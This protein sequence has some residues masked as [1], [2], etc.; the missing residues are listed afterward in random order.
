TGMWVVHPDHNE[1]GLPTLQVIHTDCIMR[2]AHIMPVFGEAF[3][4]QNINYSNSLDSF[5]TFYV[6]KFIDHS[7]FE[8]A[9]VLLVLL[10]IF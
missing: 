3:I 8:I 4:G 1:D 2:A 9:L 6:N 10:V 7:A 5:D